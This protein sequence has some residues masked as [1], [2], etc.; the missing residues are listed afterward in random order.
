MIKKLDTSINDTFLASFPKSGTTWLLNIV[1]HL[2]GEGKDNKRVDD[3]VPWL[4][5]DPYSVKPCGAKRYFKTHVP[6][7]WLPYN[8][9]AKYIYVARNPKD[10]AVSF[11]YF[12]EHMQD[13]V[14]GYKKENTIE[15]SSFIDYFGQSRVLYGCWWEHV[16][17][18]YQASLTKAN[19]LFITYEEMSKNIE[20]VISQIA[21]FMNKSVSDDEISGIAEKCTFKSMKNDKKSSMAYCKNFWRKGKCGDHVNFFTE[22]QIKI[23][24]S[25]CESLLPED[26]MKRL[27]QPN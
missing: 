24:D 2:M 4:D 7:S 3:I 18:W 16:M 8:E 6:F 27:R 26:L 17:S 10:V 9:N 12:L 22:E 11:Y 1:F 23:F 13:Q 25:K 15:M 21:A 20:S 14:I 5:C 19:V